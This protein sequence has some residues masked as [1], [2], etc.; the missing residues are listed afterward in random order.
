MPNDNDNL[1]PPNPS[2]KLPTK[3]KEF[4]SNILNDVFG[5]K[6]IKEH[7]SMTEGE[8]VMRLAADLALQIR[9]YT[10]PVLAAGGA[11]DP[12]GRLALRQLITT[13]YLQSL[14]KWHH[15]DLVL[16]CTCFM[17]EV[18]N[19]IID[20]DPRGTGKPDLLSGI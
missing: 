9:D 3:D 10:K 17:S 6:I 14:D 16:L 12:A 18:D 19:D 1:F 4:V 5:K 13:L 20:A 8:R 15:D 2:S 11:L 7:Q